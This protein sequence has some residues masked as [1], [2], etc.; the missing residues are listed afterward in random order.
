MTRLT[1]TQKEILNIT[2][3]KSRA[4]ASDLAYD[5][6]SKPGP[7]SRAAMSL[8]DKGFLRTSTN[9]EGATTYTRTAEGGKI[10]KTF[11]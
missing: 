1:E 10:A 11:N 9:K 5:L 2:D 3:A 4:T 7:I 6:D 8:V